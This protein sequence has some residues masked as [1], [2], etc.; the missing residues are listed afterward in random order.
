MKMKSLSGIHNLHMV[1]KRGGSVSI[2][3]LI[4]VDITIFGGLMAGHGTKTGRFLP[5]SQIS[6]T[7]LTWEIRVLQLQF[8]DPAR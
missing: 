3:Y 8:S 5:I 4:H 6:A 7:F 2:S 1:Y